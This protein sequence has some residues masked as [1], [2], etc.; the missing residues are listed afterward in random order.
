MA[1]LWAKKIILGEKT[2]SEVPR[3]LKAKVRDILIAA[4]REDLIDD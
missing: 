4:G 3:L 2:Y 1:E